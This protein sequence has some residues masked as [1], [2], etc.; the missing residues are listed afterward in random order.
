MASKLSLFLTELKRRKA[1]HA[2]VVYVIV[3]VGI[4]RAAEGILD[5]LGWGSLEGHGV[6]QT[7]T[8]TGP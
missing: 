7:A 6:P 1:H 4:L 2:A 5:P 3:G 8:N